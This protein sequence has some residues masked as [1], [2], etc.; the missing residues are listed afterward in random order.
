MGRIVI[1]QPVVTGLNEIDTSILP[2]GFYAWEVT[3]A[4]ERMKTGKVV[5]M[6]E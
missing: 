6:R 2:P 5:K 4:G 3:V 1:T